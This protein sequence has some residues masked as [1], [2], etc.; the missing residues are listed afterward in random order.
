MPSLVLPVCLNKIPCTPSVSVGDIA[1][2]SERAQRKVRHCPPTCFV[3]LYM[4]VLQISVE[5][6]LSGLFPVPTVD[7]EL[8]S[9]VLW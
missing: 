8:F 6:L 5:P 9:P 3:F 2:Y 1:R 4:Y 7:V